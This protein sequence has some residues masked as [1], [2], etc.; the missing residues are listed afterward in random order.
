MGKI[1]TMISVFRAVKAVRGAT[2][3][4]T[5]SKSGAPAGKSPSAL[6][7]I[8]SVLPIGGVKLSG[9]ASLWA[10]TKILFRWL[11]W[12]NRR[13]SANPILKQR[14]TPKRTRSNRSQRRALHP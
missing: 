3:G 4:K 2:K 13:T 10:I 9:L 7:V 11:G 14:P 1:G 12:L 8:T 5:R 6:G